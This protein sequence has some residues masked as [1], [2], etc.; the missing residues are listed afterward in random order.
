MKLRLRVGSVIRC[1]LL[2]LA[3]LGLFAACAAP[4]KALEIQGEDRITL[5]VGET[6]TLTTDL[7]PQ[8][9]KNLEWS[10]S[11]TSVSVDANG[12]VTAVSEGKAIVT[13]CYKDLSDRVLVDVV[14]P[15]EYLELVGR[16]A[17]YQTYTVADSYGE[18][19]ARSEQGLMSGSLTVPA[20]APTLATVQPRLD[21][22]LIR[23]SQP[24]YIDENTYAVVDAYGNEVLRVY[25]GGGYVTLE[26]VAA[27]V[28]AFGEVPANYVEGKNAEPEDSPWGEYLRLNH[29]PFS[30]DTDRYPYEPV[31]PDI[32]GCGGELDYYEIDVGTTGTDCDPRYQAKIYNDGENITR[33]A[34]RIV[35]TRYDANGDEIL[36][37]NEKYLF[38]TYNHYNDFQEYL[39]YYGGWGELFGNV[40]GGGTLSSRE[41]YAPTAYVATVRAPLP[42]APNGE[43]VTAALLFYDP[44]RWQY[45]A[46]LV[47]G[48]A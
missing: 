25:R 21:G 6:V 44:R 48:A 26:E 29:T 22:A 33:G 16:E 27:Y 2:L 38:Y 46:W 32:S 7:P 12:R 19:L 45:A 20:Q 1:L 15:S 47:A 40:T 14:S 9:T 42:A 8:Y 36:D 23:N 43:A 37:P 18:A 35:Y 24:A 28:Y 11:H 30:G 13:V 5:M 17:F 41:D 3:L 4:I 10:A 39:N 31:L 34:A